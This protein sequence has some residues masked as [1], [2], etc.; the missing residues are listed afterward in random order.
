[1]SRRTSVLGYFA[2]AALAHGAFDA[3]L[4]IDGAAP[5]A[6]LLMLVLAVTFVGLLRR[7]LRHGAVP[8]GRWLPTE[9]TPAPTEPV[10][11]SALGRLF[12]RVG[13]PLAFYG[14]AAAMIATAFGLTVLGTTYELLQHRVG[15]VFVALATGIL[16]LFGLAAYGASET[17]P[18]DVALD[19]KGLTYAGGRT[20]WRAV[21]GVDVAPAAGPRA[22]VRVHRPQ[23]I[24]RLGPAPPA[25]AGEMARAIAAAAGLSPAQPGSVKVAREPIVDGPP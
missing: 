24:L 2:L 12:F 21:L 19:A 11:A 17:M 20:A 14:S 4:S 5:V 1:V 15:V 10:P 7:A 8:D 6:M 22:F 3:S 16:A 18:L 13:S 25:R 23:G 9:E